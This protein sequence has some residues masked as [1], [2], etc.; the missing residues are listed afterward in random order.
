[1]GHD[2]H[3]PERHS[4]PIRG[5]EEA[6]MAGD[7]E[8]LN[9]EVALGFDAPWGFAPADQTS[10][11]LAAEGGA[12]LDVT[13]TSEPV[14]ELRIHGVSG[15][16]GP[17]MLE[18]LT[19]LQVAGDSVT[20]FYRRWSPDGPGR[21]SVPWKLEACSWGGL[22]EA[23]LASASWL[24]L[25]PFMM[26]N[27]AYFMVPPQDRRADEPGRLGRGDARGND[28]DE[29]G[30]PSVPHLSLSGLLVVSGFVILLRDAYSN[31][32]KRKTIG[33]LW[34]VATFWPRAVH[35]FAPPCYGERAVPEV[36]DRI[37]VLTGQLPG[38]GE[39]PCPLEPPD[40]SPAS[41]V[42]VPPGPVLLTGYSQGSIIA[43][44]VAAQLPPGV[45]EHVALL[46]LACPARRLY[47]RAF[48]ARPAYG[49]T[50]PPSRPPVVLNACFSL[51]RNLLAI[52][53]AVCHGEAFA[54]TGRE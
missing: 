49:S 33:A 22:T 17:T 51:G 25:A 7:D 54:T 24:L 36:V 4:W 52:R 8:S 11:A 21:P 34:D 10:P 20:G 37:G 30:K 1:M 28:A 14:T 44:A 47:G 50:G 42:S 45:R 41:G 48:P 35:P 16:D 46:T 43:P 13:L 38:T 32:A 18:H 6:N 53:G 26:Y 12:L 27:V 2:R 19:A 3:I 29:G 15:S 5:G 31:T 23:P 9:P 39:R 40:R